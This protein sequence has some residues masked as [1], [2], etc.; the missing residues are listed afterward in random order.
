[1][2]RGMSLDFLKEPMVKEVQCMI[3][4]TENMSEEEIDEAVNVAET[5][6]KMVADQQKKMFQQV[7]GE[8]P[9][10]VQMLQNPKAMEDLLKAMDPKA[11]EQINQLMA[12]RMEP[13]P[14]MVNQLMSQMVEA[15]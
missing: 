4:A 6:G 12:D 13:N 14:K 2:Q 7:S 10:I 5:E 8:M 9:Q 11:M 15:A 3:T 1:M